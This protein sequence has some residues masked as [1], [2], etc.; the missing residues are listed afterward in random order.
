MHPPSPVPSVVSSEGAVVAEPSLVTSVGAP[1]GAAVVSPVCDWV[2]P[3][4]ASTVVSAGVVGASVSSS[5]GH[6]ANSVQPSVSFP[7]GHGLASQ[8]KNFKETISG[9]SESCGN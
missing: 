9:T 6:N 1:V 4:V 2:V 8:Y 5:P 3:S 7:F